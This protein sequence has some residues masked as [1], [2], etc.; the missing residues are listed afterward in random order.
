MYNIF[1]AKYNTGTNDISLF[2]LTEG[3]SFSFERELAGI[4]MSRQQIGF[5][6]RIYND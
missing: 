3:K 1:C 2:T 6:E 5:Q 4:E